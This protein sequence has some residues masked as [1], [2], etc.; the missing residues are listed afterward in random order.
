MMRRPRG[1]GTRCCD[2]DIVYTGCMEA[3]TD[4]HG[5]GTRR[6]LVAL[7]AGASWLVLSGLGSF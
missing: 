6:F 5:W 3:F 7:V 1:S 2:L 4:I